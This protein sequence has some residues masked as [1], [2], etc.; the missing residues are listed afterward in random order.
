MLPEPVAAFV[1]S[2]GWGQVTASQPI[3]GGCINDGRVLITESGPR[4]FLKVNS[5]APPEMFARE[6]QGLGAL[7][8][9]PGAPRVPAVLLCAEQFLL[10]EYLPAAPPAVDYWPAL[11]RRLACLHGMSRD[12]FGF[13]HDNYLGA[14]PQPNNWTADGYAF[15][16]EHRLLFQGRRAHVRGLLGAGGLRQVERIAA[17]LPQLVPAQPASLLHG[18][19]WSG[20]I[21]PGPD[22]QACL[23]D[24]AAHYGWAEADLAMTALFGHP[25]ESFYAAYRAE[26][27]LAPG[28]RDRFELYNLYQLL[29]HLNLFGTSY[30][31]SVM[32]VLDRYH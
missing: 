12:K 14:T 20:N 29:N 15:F 30:L 21:I 5:S 24:P 26:R 28:Y 11:G 19:L 7:A 8:A 13:D 2:R 4:L 31:P 25:P 17:Q 10:L 1:A 6:A 22:G 27:P 18:D 23:I 3:T 16:S 32:S 9:A